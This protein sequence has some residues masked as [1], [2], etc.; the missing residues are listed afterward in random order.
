[1]FFIFLDFLGFELVPQICPTFAICYEMS[2][3]VN[4]PKK[5]TKLLCEK[6]NPIDFS[7]IIRRWVSFAVK[8]KL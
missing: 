5:I 4:K 8:D 1:M 7:R 3:Y 2:K 6:T